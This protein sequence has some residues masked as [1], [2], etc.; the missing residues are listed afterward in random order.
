MLL[1]NVFMSSTLPPAPGSNGSSSPE[2]RRPLSFFAPDTRC[3]LSTCWWCQ[4]LLRRVGLRSLCLPR[5]GMCKVSRADAAH[6]QVMDWPREHA[7]APT[8]C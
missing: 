8:A 7:H 6:T 1:G 2:V 4:G 3:D 5:Q